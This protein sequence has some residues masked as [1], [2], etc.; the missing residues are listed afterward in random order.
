[1]L[2][3]N[4]Y[5]FRG[6]KYAS[7]VF[8]PPFSVVSTLSGKELLLLEQIFSFNPLYSSEFFNC[9]MSEKS[10]CHFRGVQSILVLLFYF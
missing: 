7:F 4:G 5:I 8:W 1:M 9:Y 3:V 6:S 10:T 2:E